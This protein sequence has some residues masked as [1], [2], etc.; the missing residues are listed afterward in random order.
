MLYLPHMMDIINTHDWIIMTEALQTKLAGDEA[1]ILEVTTFESA[2]TSNAEKIQTLERAVKEST[3]DRKALREMVRTVTGVT[4]ITPESL[5]S[6]F[7][8]GDDALKS[9]VADLQQKLG[10]VTEDRDGLSSKHLFEIN[11]M[12]MNDILR[13]MGV[14]E[15]VWNE[16]AFTAVSNEMLKGA[17][18]VDGGFV[19]RAEDGATVFGANGAAL[20]VQE[21]I[22]NL[23]EDS[24]M[25]QFKPVKGGGGGQGSGNTTSQQPK[26]TSDEEKA[27]YFRTHGTLPPD[28]YKTA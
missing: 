12:R 4:D 14:A 24:N 13:A 20:T 27:A 21:K 18:Y 6:K 23:K 1:L 9:E 25:Y 28:A 2:A 19:Y 7:T 11:G 16:N 10:L 3:D 17:E 5:Q 26:N 15:D 22:S 8:G